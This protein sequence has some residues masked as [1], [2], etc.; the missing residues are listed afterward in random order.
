MQTETAAD[1]TPAPST[2]R[3]LYAVCRGLPPGALASVRGIDGAPVELVPH[4]GL[5]AA[6]STVAMADFG[7]QALRRHLEDLAWLETTARTHDAVIHA[8]ATQAPTAPLRFATICF[9]DDAVRARLEQW[10]QPLS[11]ALDRVEGCGEWSVKVLVPPPEPVAGRPAGLT[12]AE[13]LRLKKAQT[14]R[15]ADAEEQAAATAMG[16]H[17]QL[18]ELSRASR[19]LPA[20]DPRLSGH[21]GTMLLNAAY[22]VADD[23][24]D[25]FE[26]ALAG[27]RRDH[28]DVVVDGRGPW[29]PY[30]FAMLDEP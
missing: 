19:R 21:Q 26:A 8:V 9:D 10:Y 13:Y 2:G 24:A 29:P 12:G 6:V 11:T 18:G 20:Q 4:R 28:G 7:E 1:V 5:T 23:D 22:L 3:Y 30:S 25:A 17:E 16:I 14:V 27:V 15:H